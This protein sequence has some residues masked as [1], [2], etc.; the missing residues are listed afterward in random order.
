M[1]AIRIL[2]DYEI[3]EK[4]LVVKAGDK[5]KDQLVEYVKQKNPS[6][7]GPDDIVTDEIKREDEEI[8]AA[9]S[10]V[11]REHELELSRDV[12]NGKGD[13]HNHAGYLC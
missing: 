2:H 12:D 7:T 5:A 6:A 10:A 13:E 4:K 1:R 3:A 8:K 9:I 11:L